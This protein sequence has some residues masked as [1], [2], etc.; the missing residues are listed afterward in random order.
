MYIGL[1][2]DTHGVL[3]QEF[4][5]FFKPVDVIWHAGDWGGGFGFVQQ[6]REIK[7]VVGVYGNCDG[8]DIRQEFPEYQLFTEGGMRVLMSHIG[9]SPGHYYPRAQELIKSAKPDVFVCGHSHILKVQWDEANK[10]MYINPGAAGFQGWHLARTALRF[11]ILGEKIEEME[12]LN[13]DKN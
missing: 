3:S 11:K 4:I 12:L 13:I 9:G 2:S 8:L 10:M 7:P 6:F 1:I 5:D